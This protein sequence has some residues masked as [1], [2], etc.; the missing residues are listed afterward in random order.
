M[1]ENK[2]L[3]NYCGKAVGGSYTFSLGIPG[4]PMVYGCNRYFCR[5]KRFV[6][7]RLKLIFNT[8]FRKQRKAEKVALLGLLN[9][10]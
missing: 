6:K 9:I 5:F 10:D 2:T 3:C 1:K 7:L 4:I 8:Q